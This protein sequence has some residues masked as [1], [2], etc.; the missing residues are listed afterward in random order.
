VIITGETAKRENAKSI[1]QKVAGLA[2]DF[3]VATAGG[4]LESV[5]AGKGSGAAFYSR[6]NFSTIANIDIGGGTSNI[7]IFKNG[8]TLDS[9]CINI[10]GR[11]LEINRASRLVTHISTPM[12]RI[13]EDLNLTLKVNDPITIEMLSK[14]CDRMADVLYECVSRQQPSA[15][16][17][18]LMMTPDLKKDYT[19]DAYM[20]SG[21]VADYVYLNKFATDLEDL[22]KYNDIGPMLGFK[23]RCKFDSEHCTLIRPSETIR[24]TVIGAG[25]QTLEVSGSTIS[26]DEATLPFKNVPVIVPFTEV[27]PMDSNVIANQIKLSIETF[28]DDII[29]A[30]IAIAFNG[31]QHLSF[32][33][34]QV[35]A[36]GIILGAKKLLDMNFPLIIITEQDIGKVLGQTLKTIRPSADIICIDQIVVHDSD[37]IDIGKFLSCGSVVPIIIKTLV[38]ETKQI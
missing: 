33:D 23:V 28:Y 13:L 19:I 1:S 16:N 35:I 6:A 7:G 17:Q 18:L 32:L 10:G 15:L 34:I 29:Y 2:G 5:I 31:R 21:G 38:F 9:N 4:K 20:I 25:A 11:L 8:E 26:V 12:Q 14:I 37:Y 30:N 24:A 36:K 3:V 27:I 22:L